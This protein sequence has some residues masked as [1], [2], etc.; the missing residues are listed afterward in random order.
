MVNE[1]RGGAGG[2][3]MVVDCGGGTVDIIVHRQEKRSDGKLSCTVTAKDPKGNEY[4]TSI[5]F[6][7]T[8]G[9]A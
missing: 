9:G 3:V 1:L 5:S 4:K 8:Y 6:S 7:K 2:N